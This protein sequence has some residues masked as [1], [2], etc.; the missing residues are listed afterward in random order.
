MEFWAPL[1]KGTATEIVSNA[2]RLEAKGYT[3]AI[4]NQVYGPPW[5]ALAVAAANTSLRIESGIAMGFVRSPFETACA[6]IELDE[7]S[8]GRF[9]LGL[10]TAPQI[11]NEKFYGERFSPPIGRM[12]EL[13]QIVRQVNEAAI[14]QSTTIAPFDGEHYSLSFESLVPTFSPKTTRIPVW[15]AALRERLCELA[16]ETADGL[17]GHPIWS[18]EWTFDHALKALSKGAK[19]ANR[20]I[21]DIHVQLWLTASIDTNRRQAALRARG[22]VAFYAGIPSYHSYFDDHGFGDIAKSLV[23]AR[24]NKPV[25]DCVDL[26]P[27]EMAETFALCGTADDVGQALE[28]LGSKADSMCVKPPT[29][30]VDPNDM[31]VQRQLIDELLFA[32]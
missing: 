23:E 17:I 22:N 4:V 12:R 30:A 9:V 14:T 13:I 32:N 18:R 2:K 8:E 24:R 1:P 7:L 31:T 3:G 11:W 25:Q 15:V 26:V 29:W 20:E 28:E 5:A 6:A 16:G 19:L 10:G 27:V 21:S